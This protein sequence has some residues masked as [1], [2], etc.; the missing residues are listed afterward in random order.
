MP[1][2]VVFDT[3]IGSDID[4]TWALAFLLRCP[5]LDVKLITTDRG[6]PEYRA[7]L[8]CQILEAGG[9]QDL[10]VGLGTEWEGNTGSNRQEPCAEGYDLAGYAGEVLKDGVQA[11]INTILDSSEQITVVAIGPLPTVAEALRRE[12]RIAEN[13]RFI[14]MHGSLRLGHKRDRQNVIAEANVVNDPIACQTVF[15][16][17]WP[18]TIT[19]LDTC[20]VVQLEAEKYRRVIE[21]DD[22]LARAVMSNYAT[23]WMRSVAAE[24]DPDLWKRQSSILFD[25][26]AVYLAFGEDLLTM[27]DLPVCVT[28]DGYTLIEEGARRTNCATEWKNLAGFEDLL[29]D[30]ITQ[31]G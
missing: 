26:V 31:N 30:R 4:D 18:V 5:E 20:G 9:R 12:P 13:A 28:D 23:W 10:P 29:V 14:G 7:K 17:S 8:A 27:E 11:L 25:A 15:G 24:K 21:S 16:A 6:R 2:P 19:P 22:I 1:I 3:D